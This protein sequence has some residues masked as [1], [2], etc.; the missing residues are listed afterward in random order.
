M[1]FYTCNVE[2]IES[3][4]V[5]TIF[6]RHEYKLRYFSYNLGHFHF[7]FRT[8]VVLEQSPIVARPSL[9]PSFLIPIVGHHHEGLA[10]HS[11]SRRFS[12]ISIWSFVR[13]RH[14]FV[15]RLH[16]INGVHNVCA[17]NI[18]NDDCVDRKSRYVH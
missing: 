5:W 2:L 9:L 10:G 18:V 4:L 17:C 12:R 8:A 11:A 15:S 7:R 6:S 16:H 3:A 14:G 13:T 1:S